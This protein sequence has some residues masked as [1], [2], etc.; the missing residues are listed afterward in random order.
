M[1]GERRGSC[2][3]R[4]TGLLDITALPLSIRVPPV[5]DDPDVKHPTG[6]IDRV[7]DAVIAHADAPQVAGSME[8]LDARRSGIVSEPVHCSKDPTADGIR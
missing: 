8:P 5:S 2:R 1:G 3:V 7:D 4:S 6:V